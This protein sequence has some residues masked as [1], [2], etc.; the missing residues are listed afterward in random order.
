MPTTG[1]IEVSTPKMT[2]STS[3]TQ[4][5]N[6]F[7]GF[8][9]NVIQPYTFPF[10]GTVTKVLINTL[11]GTDLGNG[12]L[13]IIQV[14]GSVGGYNDLPNLVFVA[15]FGIQEFIVDYPFDANDGFQF[16]IQS[17]NAGAKFNITLE[18]EYDLV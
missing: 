17:N 2:I 6:L 11:P 3:S 8:P 4:V 7:G 14:I 15:Q 16:Q 18:V 9:D 10:P 13:N 5:G 12:H 1:L